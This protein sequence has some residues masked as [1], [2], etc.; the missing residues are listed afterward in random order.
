[1]F[2][3]FMGGRCG[4]TKRPHIWIHSD[5]RTG[6]SLPLLLYLAHRHATAPALEADADGRGLFERALLANTNVG[7]ANPKDLAPI[8]GG[9]GVPL[10]CFRTLCP[11]L[12]TA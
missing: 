10:F 1:M 11:S 8:V 9:E 12:L 7:G 6:D 4:K 5:V 2:Q 3:Y